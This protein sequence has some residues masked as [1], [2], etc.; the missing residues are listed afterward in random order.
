MLKPP[1]K[2]F[3]D[4]GTVLWKNSKNGTHFVTKTTGVSETSLNSITKIG[5]Q[6]NYFILFLNL[7]FLQI[8]W[9]LR[10]GLVAFRSPG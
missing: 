2:N 7:F 6:S 1:L 3:E 4:Y 8:W 10:S 5:W 9:G